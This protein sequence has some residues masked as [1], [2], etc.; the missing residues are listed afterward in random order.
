M[1]DKKETTK[2]AAKSKATT[3]EPYL[4]KDSGNASPKMKSGTQSEKNKYFVPLVLLVVVI[5]II[6][7][8][9]Y[10]F[11]DERNTK[12]AQNDTKDNTEITEPASA[13]MVQASPTINTPDQLVQSTNET[14]DEQANTQTNELESQQLAETTNKDAQMAG[15]VDDSASASASASASESESIAQRR[16][17]YEN[18]I[19]SKQ[20]QLQ[21]LMEQREKDRIET[22]AKLKAEYQRIQEKQQ[23]I[24]MK[25]QELQ[26]E[27]YNLHEKRFQLMREA[28][29]QN[30]QQ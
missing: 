4:K 17:E 22:V 21:A 27:I 9:I 11:Y 20:K 12:L 10:K 13:A 28:R 24:R 8:T 1:T 23:E 14:I 6:L 3:T 2:T 18:E 16:Q 30:R 29:A 26:K 5:A 15:S 25:A 7:T 19:E